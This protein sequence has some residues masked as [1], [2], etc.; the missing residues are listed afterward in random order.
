MSPDRML[1]IVVFIN[2]GAARLK[3]LFWVQIDETMSWIHRYEVPDR[4]RFEH[5][6]IMVE[7]VFLCVHETFFLRAKNGP[8]PPNIGP[9]GVRGQ[10][11]CEVRTS[12]HSRKV[13]EASDFTSAL[14]PVR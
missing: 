1:I 11:V 8:Y 5:A 14:Y 10:F 12:V 3:P 7:G 2:T 4:L 13:D 6:S 9:G